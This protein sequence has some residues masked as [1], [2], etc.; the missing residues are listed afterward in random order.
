MLETIIVFINDI[1][2]NGGR[3]GGMSKLLLLPLERLSDSL[4]NNNTYSE[5]I[6][7]LQSLLFALSIR[8]GF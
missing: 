1:I 5:I 6:Q 7:F 8:N 2:R 4:Q 3:Y